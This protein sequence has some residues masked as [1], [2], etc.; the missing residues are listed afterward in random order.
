MSDTADVV[1]IGAGLFGLALGFELMRL[2]RQKI[3]VLEQ[4]YTGSGATGRNIGRVRTSQFSED[5]A[6]LAK[7]AFAKHG[8]LSDE[9]GANTLFW[10]PG[11][12]LVFYEEDETSQID[13]IASMLSGLGLDPEVHRGEA[14]VRRLPIL[15]GGD[16]PVGCLIRPDAAVHHDALLY[17]YRAAI[18]RAGVDIREREAVTRIVRRGESIEG[19]ETESGTIAAP[20]VVNAT[21]GWSRDVSALAD[22]KVPNVPLRREVVVSDSWKPLMDTMIT[23]YRP[24]EGWFHQTLRGE[25]VMGVV[26]PD[27]TPGLDL[28]ATDTHLFRV[29]KHLLRKAP[30]LGHLR[31]VRQWGGTYDMTPDRKPMIGP[32]R[33]R[34]GFVQA[35]GDN[36]RG[37]ALIPYLAELLALWLETGSRPEALAS[38]DANR[39]EGREDTPVVVGDYYAAYR[40]T[41]PESAVAQ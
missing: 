34:T 33:I 30:R 29:A 14:V 15:Q 19:V 36:G 6:M 7:S 9:L 39:Y 38:F 16:T 31:V 3:I 27:Q 4:R 12:A 22:V 25:V 11:Y 40:K 10:R 35:N 23:F 5:L 21:G 17:A 8:R 20:I 37:I 18:A 28:T 41:K 26:H 24:L 32:M 2:R 13:A 1:I